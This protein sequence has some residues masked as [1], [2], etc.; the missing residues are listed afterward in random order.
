M[1]KRAAA[2]PDQQ[3][4]LRTFTPCGRYLDGQAGQ[5][6]RP[7][8]LRA[9]LSVNRE[10]PNFRKTS[11]AMLTR[12]VPRPAGH[13]NAA[14]VD[15]DPIAVADCADVDPVDHRDVGDDRS[16]GHDGL[17]LGIDDRHRGMPAALQAQDRV[18]SHRAALATGK[19][20]H[21]PGNRTAGERMTGFKHDARVGI[22]PAQETDGHGRDQCR[23]L[24]PPGSDHAPLQH[25]GCGLSATSF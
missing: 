6:P 4:E 2:V 25:R 3:A 21:R 20:E 18:R 23:P 24:C 22:D 12:P 19:D 5:N 14:V 17:A 9:V 16:D 7:Q 15:D 13:L 8:A 11:S 1:A 10:P